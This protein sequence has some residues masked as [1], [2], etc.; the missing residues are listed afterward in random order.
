M[1]I[2][3]VP[4]ATE[5]RQ[6]GPPARILAK[7]IS[8]FKNQLEVLSRTKNYTGLHVL[9]DPDLQCIGEET[10]QLVRLMVRYLLVENPSRVGNV[11]QLHD[12]MIFDLKRIG[13][14]DYINY[15]EWFLRSKVGTI[16]VM[17][18][19]YRTYASASD[20]AARNLTNGLKTPS[21]GVLGDFIPCEA[22][23]IGLD[24][25]KM[26]QFELSKQFFF[27]KIGFT[28][29]DYTGDDL[30]SV[31]PDRLQYGLIHDFFKR[32]TLMKTNNSDR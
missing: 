4:A 29:S 24:E 19:L 15:F 26:E 6:Y 32:M 12:L 31:I 27:D 28:S 14:N 16:G 18:T 25:A 2:Q 3:F 23:R 11:K 9:V 10:F 5:R 17:I 22:S 30:Y 7:S 13:F 20:V 1:E 21:R 8:F